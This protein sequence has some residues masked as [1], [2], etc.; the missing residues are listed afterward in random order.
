M[1]DR[2][3]TP[4][5]TLARGSAPASLVCPLADLRRSPDGARDRQLLL[6]DKVIILGRS[7]SYDYVR[8]CKD[9]YHGFVARQALGPPHAVTHRISAASSHVYAGA[10][11]KSPDLAALSF[12]SG[13]MAIRET[14]DFIETDLG[15]IPKQ[16]VCAAD[17]VANDPADV[18][19]LYLGTPYLWGG[20]SRW[21]IDCS[22]LV[23]AALLAC[24]VPCPGDS[25]QQ[26][27]AFTPE[28]GAGQRG[29]LLFWKG[30]VAMLLDDSHLIHAN[31]F[32]MQTVI[33]SVQSAVDRIADPVLAHLRPR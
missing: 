19:L 22:G 4:D 31:A 26:Q 24:G 2:R 15:H 21:G 27:A 28:T 14:D 18:A 10:D 20:N 1:T 5:P 30:H 13:V 32:H 17:S 8:A 29:D 12:G 7:G 6:G 25:D 16:H 11:I 9:G 33:E 23:Q 3:S